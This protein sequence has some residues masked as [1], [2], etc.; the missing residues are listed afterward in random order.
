MSPSSRLS[1]APGRPFAERVTDLP[2]L[3][4]GVSTEY[5]AAAAAGSLDVPRLAREYPQFTQFLEVG[6]ETVKGLDAD[7]LRWLEGGRPTTYH[8]LDVNLHEPTDFDDVWL[9]SVTDIT[10]TLKPAWLCGDA[11]LWHF[12][13]RDR[14]HMLL[15]PP[16]LSRDAA[17][18]AAAGIT[19]LR[20][21]TGYEVLPENPPGSFFIGD[22]HLLEYFAEVVTHADSGML[23]DAAHLAI[24]Q[25]I[26]GHS[27]IDGLDDFPLERVVEIHVAGGSVRDHEGYRWVDD[28]HT[29]ALL[30]DTWTIFDALVDRCPNLRAVVFECERNTLDACL[31]SFGRLA[32][33]LAG[34]GLAPGLARARLSNPTR[35]NEP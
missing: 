29:A 8:F 9:K 2:M 18:D 12:G 11:G 34:T 28:D 35:A 31:S 33:R 7:A 30:P 6:V 27:A 19:R 32:E 17:R 14:G 20:D 3:G 23:I 22:L 26:Q 13:R 4:L 16:I 5:G 1:V 15:L 10:D 21:H 24:Y 25:Q